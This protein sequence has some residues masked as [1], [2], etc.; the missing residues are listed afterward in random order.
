V[1]KGLAYDFSV[2]GQIS[3]PLQCL[4]RVEAAN[5]AFYSAC[6]TP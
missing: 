5:G 3:D 4:E 2:A 6:R 1:I